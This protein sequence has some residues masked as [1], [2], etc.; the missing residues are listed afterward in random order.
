MLKYVVLALVVVA[1]G[2]LGSNN[3]SPQA[4]AALLQQDL[5][6]E[7]Q[8]AF[9]RSVTGLATPLIRA[10]I[11]QDSKRTNYLFFSIYD[12]S[13]PNGSD[14]TAVAVY[15]HVIPIHETKPSTATGS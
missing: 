6:S 14:L 1:A 11:E 7:Q 4:Y 10:Y 2:L 9:M 5:Q 12:T 8:S 13:L 3:P 15:N